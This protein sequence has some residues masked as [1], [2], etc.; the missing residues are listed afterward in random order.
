ML[1]KGP[2]DDA[3]IPYEQTMSMIGSPARKLSKK[4]SATKWSQVTPTKNTSKFGSPDRTSKRNL[5]GVVDH[6][7]VDKDILNLTANSDEKNPTDPSKSRILLEPTDPPTPP[8]RKH[9]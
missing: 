8:F 3:L 4:Q 7:Q 6:E 5:T 2:D 1:E 9:T